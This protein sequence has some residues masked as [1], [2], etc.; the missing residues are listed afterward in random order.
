PPGR[1]RCAIWVR[2]LLS[3]HLCHRPA[4]GASASLHR[5]CRSAAL[6]TFPDRRGAIPA[7][8]SLE[9]QHLLRPARASARTPGLLLILAHHAQRHPPRD[10]GDG[11][12]PFGPP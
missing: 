12:V 3:R 4:S 5:A 7:G 8:L 1:S 11:L 10:G 9:T 6:A 2:S